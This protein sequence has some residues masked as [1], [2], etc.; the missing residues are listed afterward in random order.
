[1]TPMTPAFSDPLHAFVDHGTIVRPPLGPGPLTGLSVAVKDLFDWAGVPTGAGNPTWLATHPVPDQDA[2]AV[3]A[4]SL[5]GATLKGKTITDELAYSIHGDNLHYGTPTNPAAPGRVPGGSSSGSA[6]AVAGGLVDAA[7]G[8]DTGGSIRVPAA[9]CGLFGIRT[10]HA[11]VNRSGLVGLSPSFDTVGW[12]GREARTLE[13]LASV[14]VPGFKKD[15]RLSRI[16]TLPEADGLGDPETQDATA[17]TVKRLGLPWATL[18]GLTAPFGGLEG[19][20]KT[21]A[22]IQGWEAWN[23]HGEWITSC[24]P[25]LAPAIANRFQVA[26]RISLDEVDAARVQLKRWRE[27]LRQALGDKGVLVLPTTVGP[28]PRI[29]E[30]DAVV[31]EVRV[32]TMRLTCLAG[33]AGLPQVTV[34]FRGGDGLPRG[35]GL[36]GPAESDRA[37]IVLAARAAEE[38]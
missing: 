9:Y 11:A 15:Y 6:V 29:G 34:P 5:A 22:T 8:T 32:Q 27:A 26:S 19:L 28:A 36:V 21:Y 2:V 24:R 16:W 7:L 30:E 25:V 13:T 35:V 17:E 3:G 1:M 18:D 20:R 31:D 14:L 37:L 33:L 12:L 23:L 38:A 4:L 10:T